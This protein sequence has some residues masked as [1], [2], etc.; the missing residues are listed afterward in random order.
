MTT[1]VQTRLTGPLATTRDLSGHRAVVTGGAGG[2]GTV[3]TRALAERGA[4]VYIGARHTERA[5]VVRHSVL[6]AHRLPRTRIQVV[7]L[8]LTDADSIRRF[9]D[10]VGQAPI[11]TLVLNA[12][13]SSVPFGRDANGTELQF[14]TNHLGHF[15][16]TGGLLPALESSAGARVVTVSSALYPNGKLDLGRLDDPSG[17]SPG[18]AY[19][20]SKLANAV[21][22]VELDRRLVTA[23]G[24]V[25]SFGAHPG[26]ARTPL[27]TTYPSAVTRVVTGM[28]ARTIGRDPE[29]ADIGILAAALSTEV[30]PDLFWGPIGSRRN[31]HAIGVPYARPAKDRALGAAL[32]SASET[33]TGVSFLSGSEPAIR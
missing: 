9:A 26:M 8:D 23:G 32:W 33:L 6:A 12:A 16:L 18:R 27:H 11:Q 5:E 25:R 13:M 17:Y 20:R 7:A 10:E 21:F 2:I 1:N 22:A 4:T 28:L 30:T 24:A 19:I 29:P 3:T 15:A 14:A 31:P